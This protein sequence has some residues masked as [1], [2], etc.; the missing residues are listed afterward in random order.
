MG[1]KSQRKGRRGN[2]QLNPVKR[3]SKIKKIKRKEKRQIWVDEHEIC[4]CM[5]LMRTKM[6]VV[7]GREERVRVCFATKGGGFGL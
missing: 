4:L 3:K 2:E 5:L 1:K 7:K 6:V